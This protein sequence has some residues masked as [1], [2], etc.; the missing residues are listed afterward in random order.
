LSGPD[1]EAAEWRQIEAALERHPQVAE[2]TMAAREDTSGTRRPWAY[3]ATRPVG[4]AG[5]P[6][7][8]PSGLAVFHLNRNETEHLYRQVFESRIYLRH[9]IALPD[10]ACILDVGANIGLF[11]LF[12][13][14]VCERPR[15]FAFEPSPP[16]F[17]RLRR[18]VE[19]YGL[20]V[21]L[22]PCAVSNRAG[23]APFTVYP[24]A[25][26]MSGLYADPLAE[27]RLF[28]ATVEEQL[29]E[30]GDPQVIAEAVDQLAAGRFAVKVVERPLR[31]ISSVLEERG[32]ER[33]DLLKVD[34]EKSELDV[35]AGIAPEDWAKILQV[36]VEVHLEGWLGDVVALLEARGF[37]VATEQDSSLCATGIHHVY[38]RR[39]RPAD[40]R[41]WHDRP[42]R[43][44][45]RRDPPPAPPAG[46]E[47][48][49]ESLR[50]LLRREL[51]DAMM[52]AGFTLLDELPRLPDGKLDRAGLPEPDSPAYEN[53]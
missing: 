32:I 9:G 4:A 18:N 26:V 17:E 42:R 47:P 50:E 5:P 6:H 51:P 46:A 13:H 19:L 21:E 41:V 15:I 20:A 37:T 23:T 27:E 52:P 1:G 34:A 22:A 10:D 39:P 2:A 44:L 7:L 31:T 43:A 14:C 40:G 48:L 45:E 25:S 36:A 11:T 33:V 49:G 53:P 12:A 35:F 28:R 38:A 24:R 3:V 16:A 29:R 30:V 8:L